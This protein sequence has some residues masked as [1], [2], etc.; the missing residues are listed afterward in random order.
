VIH[1]LVRRRLGRPALSPY[2]GW[3]VT[4]IVVA[5]A[6]TLRLH[7]LGHPA[8]IVFDETY[9]ANEGRSLL[10]YGVEYD[11][12]NPKYVVHPPLG[13]WAIAL[14]IKMFGF[15]EFG[16]RIA[17]AVAGIVSVLLVVRIGRRLFRSD[18]LGGVAG[19]LVALDGMHLVMSRI[20]LLDVF[21]MV[22][23]VAAFG[24]LVLDREQRRARWLAAL[25]AGLDPDR[26][27]RA[28]RPPF[29]VPWWRLAA[30]VLAGCAL[31]VK[32]SAIWY[33]LA[34][35]LLVF[36]WEAG[37]RRSA[38]VRHPWRRALVGEGGWLLGFL[39]LA[40]AAYVASWAGWFVTDTGYFRHWLRDSGAGNDDSIVGALTNW[41]HYHHEMLKFHTGMSTQHPYQSWPWQWLLQGRPVVFYRNANV[42]CGAPA[43]TSVVEMLG[44]PVLWW[45]FLPALAGLGWLGISRRDWRAG[46]LGL[47][48]AAGIVP[49]IWNALDGRTMFAFYALPAEPFLA[50]AVAYV[51]GA[52]IG[53]PAT[54]PAGENRRLVGSV[55]A[56][57]YVVLVVACFAY[58]YPVYVAEPMT[59]AQWNARMWL[60]R[61]WM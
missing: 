61:L 35:V 59:L 55:V 40:A 50:L 32:W 60:G 45:S 36:W 7:E 27:G 49:W 16:W 20:A 10:E 58:F 18:L 54:D 30:G 8:G 42:A 28:G 19:L 22:F 33:V 15:N 41:W 25:E 12:G 24:C 47:C 11:K 4:G 34:F 1:E 48:V 44:T 9:Y 46:A 56:G 39:G 31:G 26:P 13:K 37:A 38:G 29:A 5:I 17:A 52:I 57:A 21:L 14:G 6:A 2:A 3:V 43:C 53:P 51:L 23:V